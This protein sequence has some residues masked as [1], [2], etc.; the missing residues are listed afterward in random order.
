MTLGDTI[1]ADRRSNL[2]TDLSD[3]HPVSFEYTDALA[4][5]D[6]QLVSP[7]V[8]TGAVKLDRDGQLQC[9]SCHDPHDDTYGNFLVMDASNGAAVQDLPYHL[10]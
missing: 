5:S 9:T 4:G 7:S 2:G 1:P 3:D 10:S 8:L 6:G